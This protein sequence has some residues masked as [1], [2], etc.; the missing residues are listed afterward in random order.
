M[1]AF[2]L[3][4][5]HRRP[6]IPDEEYRQTATA[7]HT[8]DVVHPGGRREADIPYERAKALKAQAS[9]EGA[10]WRRLWQA[11]EGRRERDHKTIADRIFEAAESNR[12]KY[13]TDRMVREALL[14]AIGVLVSEPA[15]EVAKLYF[16]E[17]IADRG[18]AYVSSLTEATADER[19]EG[20]PAYLGG[21]GI[22]ADTAVVEESLRRSIGSLRRQIEMKLKETDLCASPTQQGALAEAQ[23]ALTGAFGADHGGDAY[24]YDDYD[25]EDYR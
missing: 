4:I 1:Q 5:L 15:Y 19:E 10:E 11:P 6:E 7:H 14:P 24:D 3:C 8:F 13:L 22:T 9:R 25:G 2:Y 21:W 17:T 18:W 23:W 12:G 20:A 16:R